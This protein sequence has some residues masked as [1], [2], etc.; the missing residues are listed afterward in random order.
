ML[1][2]AERALPPLE[3]LP[4]VPPDG[5]ITF[6]QGSLAEGFILVKSVHVQGQRP[7]PQR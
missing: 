5:S 7:L 2:P 1:E 3:A 6:V 4:D